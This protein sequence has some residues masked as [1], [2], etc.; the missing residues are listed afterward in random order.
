MLRYP[1]C[2]GWH[3]TT[4][5][6]WLYDTARGFIRGGSG[7]FSFSGGGNW[8]SNPESGR[9]VAVVGTGL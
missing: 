3:G 2:A 1:S 9:G 5:T 7:V 8:T 6:S 4:N